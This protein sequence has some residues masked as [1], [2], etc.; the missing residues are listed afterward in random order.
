V[1]YEWIIHIDIRLGIRIW[2]STL[3]L[4]RE[5]EVLFTFGTVQIRLHR[6]TETSKLEVLGGRRRGFPDD[7]EAIIVLIE[8]TFTI[9]LQPVELIGTVVGVPRRE[10]CEKFVKNGKVIIVVG[11]ALMSFSRNM[12]AAG[13]YISK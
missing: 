2:K 3:K 13:R 4:H 12:L 8:F 9:V 1:C 5:I 6:L 7:L 11:E 10:L